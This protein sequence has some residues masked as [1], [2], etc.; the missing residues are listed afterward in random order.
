MLLVTVN[1]GQDFTVVLR[2]PAQEPAV[3]LTVT[4]QTATHQVTREV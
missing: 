4:N 3:S 2:F 1:A